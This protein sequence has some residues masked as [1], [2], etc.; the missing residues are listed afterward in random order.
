MEGRAAPEKSYP[1]QHYEYFACEV[2]VLAS[3][4]KLAE[5]I[6]V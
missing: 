1:C 4:L 6:L 2:I 5:A 3:L